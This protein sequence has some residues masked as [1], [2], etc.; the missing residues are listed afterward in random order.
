ML[1]CSGEDLNGNLVT[2]EWKLD[3][4]NGTEMSEFNVSF[5]DGKVT[6]LPSSLDVLNSTDFYNLVEKLSST[7]FV[8]QFSN[9]LGLKTSNKKINKI[10][11]LK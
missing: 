4:M 1:N 11:L 8:L 7:R 3:Y 10:F 5:K 6:L 2:D 9:G